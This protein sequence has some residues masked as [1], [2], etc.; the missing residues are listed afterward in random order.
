MRDS[1]VLAGEYSWIHKFESKSSREHVIASNRF[2][3]LFSEHFTF[4]QG[5]S[6]LHHGS[7]GVLEA[8]I[9]MK[10]RGWNASTQVTCETHAEY[11]SW[12]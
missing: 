6:S 3:G 10:C 8:E 1:L 11:E 7:C 12:V 4:M 5:T 9:Y 2:Q